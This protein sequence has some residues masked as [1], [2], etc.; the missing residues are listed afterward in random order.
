MVEHASLYDD[1]R[2]YGQ[3]RGPGRQH[4]GD[5]QC[6]VDAAGSHADRRGSADALTPAQPFHPEEI[7]AGRGVEGKRTHV[8]QPLVDQHPGRF[9]VQPLEIHPLDGHVVELDESLLP[10]PLDELATQR[11]R[12][13]IGQ[14]ALPQIDNDG[15]L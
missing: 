5:S 8:T 6:Q 4:R 15:E 7:L 11:R 14:P 2:A 9:L 10:V 12:L 3:A 13:R 1:S